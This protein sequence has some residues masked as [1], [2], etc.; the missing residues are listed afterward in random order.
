[1]NTDSELPAHDLDDIPEALLVKNRKPLTP[2]ASEEGG[3]GDG[4]SQGFK[5]GAQAHGQEAGQ[6]RPFARDNL[7][8]RPDGLREGSAGAR[9]VDFVCR[10]QG[11]T[12]AELCEMICWKQCLPFLRK[13]C[14]QAGVKLR[15]EKSEGE[16]TRYYGTVRIGEEGQGRLKNRTLTIKPG[17]N[18]GLFCQRRFTH[19]SSSRRRYQAARSHSY[20]RNRSS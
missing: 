19:V 7:K 10:K 1:M 5:V 12:N 6:G 20:P 11:A 14:D 13:S 15:T 16:R 18:A 4:R 9:L 2:G 3:N 17:A 8:L